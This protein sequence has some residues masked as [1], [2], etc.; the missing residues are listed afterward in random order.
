MK[1]KFFRIEIYIFLSVT[2]L[3]VNITFSV[4]QGL[5]INEVMSSNS[6]AIY[7][8]DGDTPDWIEIFNSS[9]SVINLDGYG[10]SDTLNNDLFWNFPALEL[11]AGKHLLIFASGKD[12]KIPPLNWETIIDVSDQWKYTVPTAEPSSSW[13]S[14][15]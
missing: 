11:D 7:D 1:L 15:R 12:R 9:A 8:E 10:L 5:K 13:R 14:E 6:L 3:I 4:A 2:L